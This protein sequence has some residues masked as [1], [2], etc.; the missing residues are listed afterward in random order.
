METEIRVVLSDGKVDS[1]EVTEK[2][3]IKRK[4][5]EAELRELLKP[6]LGGGR[7]QCG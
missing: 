5:A 1:I 7:K 2:K 6:I 4:S 3:P